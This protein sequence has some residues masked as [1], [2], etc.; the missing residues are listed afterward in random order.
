MTFD[1]R[2]SFAERRWSEQSFLE[3]FEGSGGKGSFTVSAV[4]K[5]AL[6][7]REAILDVATDG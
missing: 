7:G 3:G 1:A 5:F 6:P 2:T 4:K